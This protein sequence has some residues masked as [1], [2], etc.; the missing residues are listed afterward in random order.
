MDTINTRI[1]VD[2]SDFALDKGLFADK[3]ESAYYK[4]NASS[5]Q[6]RFYG[7]WLIPDGIQ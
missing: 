5:R 2:D 1:H 3:Y 7:N 4:Q 6:R